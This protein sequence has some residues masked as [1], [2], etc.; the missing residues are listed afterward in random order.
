MKKFLETQALQRRKI[1]RGYLILRWNTIYIEYVSL[2]GYT[3]D[4]FV[5]FMLYL[6]ILT[7]HNWSLLPSML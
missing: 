1:L 5:T 4:T 3:S 2:T 7:L 6:T